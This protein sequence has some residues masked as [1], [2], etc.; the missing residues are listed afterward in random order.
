MRSTPEKRA[1]LLTMIEKMAKG[2][3]LAALR[4]DG[5]GF[6]ED[7]DE[8]AG[9]EGADDDAGAVD[10][11]RQRGRPTAHAIAQ[12]RRITDLL[13]QRAPKRLKKLPAL[14]EKWKGREEQ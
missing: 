10:E 12:T 8:A 3:D 11:W 2:L 4:G 6:G 1:E 5:D 13:Q 9:D 14:L 7:E